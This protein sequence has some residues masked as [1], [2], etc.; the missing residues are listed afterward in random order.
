M[1]GEH[2]H[3]YTWDGYDRL[4]CTECGKAKRE[5]ELEQQLAQALK[6]NTQAR[7]LLAG[8][9]ALEPYRFNERFRNVMLHSMIAERVQVSDHEACPYCVGTDIGVALHDEM[10]P[11]GFPGLHIN[12]TQDCPWLQARSFLAQPKE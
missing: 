3:D 8:L 9:V 5:E 7:V 11:L 10:K 2:Q 6:E 1:A 12:H 4:S